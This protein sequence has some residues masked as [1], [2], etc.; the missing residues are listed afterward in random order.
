LIVALLSLTFSQLKNLLT[1]RGIPLPPADQ[2]QKEILVAILLASDAD[3]SANTDAASVP[4]AASGC[5]S[6]SSSELEQLHLE[7]IE[8]TAAL[9]GDSIKNPVKAQA[10]R[11]L[12]TSIAD[13]GVSSLSM[14]IPSSQGDIKSLFTTT[15]ALT[16][17]D[18][19]AISSCCNSSADLGAAEAYFYRAVHA[20]ASL[21]PS[22]A[23]APAEVPSKDLQRLMAFC[24][25]LLLL[26]CE[27]RA[28]IADAAESVCCLRGMS[29]LLND[30]THCEPA[31]EVVCAVGN[32]WSKCRET[33]AALDCFIKSAQGSEACD[34]AIDSISKP[35]SAISACAASALVKLEESSWM[36]QNFGS[37]SKA[38][39]EQLH[40]DIGRCVDLIVHLIA[41][42]QSHVNTPNVFSETNTVLP[43]IIE[44]CSSTL[45]L[46]QH[47]SASCF[48][49]CPSASS[50][51]P[52]HLLLGI[53]PRPLDFSGII[54]LCAEGSKV[55]DNANL[56]QEHS[57]YVQFCSDLSRSVQ[58]VKGQLALPFP[59]NLP[60][61]QEVARAASSAQVIPQTLARHF[62]GAVL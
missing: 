39:V 27:Q 16:S 11:R 51:S 15:R 38:F 43:F 47:A 25:S 9:R 18:R 8:Q 41:S 46:L 1:A 56:V 20:V 6:P 14:H 13:M 52:S 61:S 19:L 32:A 17:A 53:T 24:E 2:I 10:L 30:G 44:Q 12:T 5:G 54:S 49:S 50:T 42:L 37:L 7:I 33:F 62:V 3:D 48:Y 55:S 59:P 29:V 23:S 22:V 35:I 40:S 28:S 21:R 60:A 34:S 4:A 45:K 26:A 36:L 58:L 31:A 57:S